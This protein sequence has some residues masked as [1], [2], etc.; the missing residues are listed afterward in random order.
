MK[1]TITVIWKEQ[2]KAIKMWTELEAEWF[3]FKWKWT[4][5]KWI[6]TIKT[7]YKEDLK[8]EFF[9]EIKL[10]PIEDEKPKRKKKLKQ[11]K[12]KKK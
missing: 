7:G 3:K 10:D 2:K 4:R 1:A 11:G 5:I 9:K 6:L 8:D 12:K